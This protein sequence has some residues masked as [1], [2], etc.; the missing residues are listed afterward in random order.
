MSTT[1]PSTPA[2]KRPAL[3]SVTRR[4]LVSVFARERGGHFGVTLYA[5]SFHDLVLNDIAGRITSGAT[6]VRAGGPPSVELFVLGAH[7]AGQPLNHQLTDRGG[8]V[9]REA[10]TT[11][12]YRLFVLPTTPA[13]PGLCQVDPDDPGAHSIVGELWSLPVAGI[14]SLLA[15]LPAPMTLGRVKLIDGT[16][17]IGFLCEPSALADAEEITAYRGWRAYL[18]ASAAPSPP[19]RHGRERCES[20]IIVHSRGAS[21]AGQSRSP[22]RPLIVRAALPVSRVRVGRGLSAATPVRCLVCNELGIPFALPIPRGD[23]SGGRFADQ[24]DR[25]SERD[26]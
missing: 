8:H 16:N 19:H 6:I 23:W 21:R 4:T 12:R 14:G 13:K 18:S 24:Q 11:H 20:P 10:Q 2:V 7:L 9:L 15:D 17:P 5:P 1:S 3:R 22:C 25:G 26:T